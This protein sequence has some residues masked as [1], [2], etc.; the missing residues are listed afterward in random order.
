MD[1]V[2]E[3]Q[4]TTRIYGNIRDGDYDDAITVLKQQL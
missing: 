2:P 1:E 3:G 4:L